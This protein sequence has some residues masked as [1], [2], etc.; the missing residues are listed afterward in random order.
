M[1][2]DIAFLRVRSRGTGVS[3]RGWH[4]TGKGLSMEIVYLL[5]RAA[6]A[7][8]GMVLFTRVNGL[9]SFS[10][11]AG[12]DFGITIAFGSVLASMVMATEAST[13]WI[14][15]GAL[16]ALFVVQ[17]TISYFRV[18]N[19]IFHDWIGND[20]LLLMRNGEFLE[21]NLRKGRVTR[22]DVYGKLREANALQLSQVR[23]V[24]LEDTG[25]VSVLHG[26]EDIDDILL[27]GVRT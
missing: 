17:R 2:S 14:N 7:V 11:M 26:P 24:I 8:A 27:E 20:P 16:L 23:A 9:R 12:Y 15:F 5:L 6:I 10:K 3:A 19:D 13:F 4:P 18:E 1:V 22:A 21:H 25:D